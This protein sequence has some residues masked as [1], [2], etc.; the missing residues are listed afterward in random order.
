MIERTN[1]DDVYLRLAT[2]SLMK[3][4]E[5]NMELEQVEDGKIVKYPVPVFYNKSQDS[6]FMQDYF[7]QYSTTCHEIEYAD[8]DYDQEPFAI[9]QL[10]S[11]SI[12]VSDMTN[13]FVR[14]NHIMTVE[15][16]NGYEVKKGYSS[17]LFVLP[18]ELKY[19]VSI[20]TEDTIQSFRIAQTIMEGLFK[21]AVIHFDFRHQRIRC[22]LSLD[23]SFTHDKKVDFTYNDDQSQSIK[24]SVDVECYYPVFDKT[25]TLF[26]GNV[27][28]NFR[29]Y[30]ETKTEVVAKETVTYD[31]NKNM[32]LYSTTTIMSK[33]QI[34]KYKALGYEI[35]ETKDFDPD[36]GS[37]YFKTHGPFIVDNK[38]Y[39]LY[40]ELDN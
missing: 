37:G 30:I 2:I 31:E 5:E 17:A 7:T 12:K 18:L 13:R 16:E 15:D 3:Y 25:T 4:L 10:N 11:F 39:I 35:C 9:V 38:E 14:G 40:K 1:V 23:S 26:R 21:N 20:R 28:K 8:G 29:H 22:N 6:Q 34:E 33:E 36:A 27:I 32:K 19:E 24:F